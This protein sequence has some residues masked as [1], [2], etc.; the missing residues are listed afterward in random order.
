MPVNRRTF[1]KSAG[2]TTSI[3]ALAGCLSVD[4]TTTTTES[5]GGDS[6][7]EDNESSETTTTTVEPGEATYWHA[8]TEA[9][10]DALEADIETFHGDSSQSIKPVKIADFVSKSN[11]AIP[12][13]DGPHIFEWAHDLGGDYWER[14]FL[15]DQSDNVDID[16]ES[17]FTKP[18]ASAATWDG[19]L[20]GLPFA[21]ETVGLIYNKD[22]VDEPPETLDEMKTIMEEHHDPDN[23]TFGLSY[24]IDPYFISAFPH[25]FGGYYYDAEK[26]ELGL[27]NEE[28]LRGFR[29]VIEDLWPYS[30]NDP[31]YDPQAAVFA[32]GNAPFAI[33]GPW[34]I[35]GLDFDAGVTALPTVDGSQPNPYTGVQMQY[36]SKK[37][38]DGTDVDA[39]AAR[40]F[41]EWYVTNEEILLS[42]AKESGFIPV[43]K[44]V[45]QSDELGA[46]T[47]G[48]AKSVETGRP[49]PAH[50]KMQKVWAPV[51]D[52]FTKALNGSQSLAD[53]M[54]EAEASIRDNWD[55]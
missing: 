34:F 11:S 50:P 18:G 24:N 6:N 9:D 31:S 53:A 2:V 29:V 54:T 36:F 19:K 33:N 32:D 46:T 20:I 30:P 16:L 41:V 4:E 25:A 5:S 49:M 15:T 40:S 17:T 1:I 21:A 52:A 8:R 43:H 28:T 51:D 48:F 26:D 27:T 39:E 44:E 47:S 12:A 38:E 37:M 35:A 42:N 55:N 13:G 14:G 22:L 3:A 23:N 45:A 7:N 10:K